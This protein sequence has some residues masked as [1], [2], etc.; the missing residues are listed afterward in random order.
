MYA[1]P[2]LPG[3]AVGISGAIQH[4]A[5]MSSSKVGPWSCLMVCQWA[6]S[7]TPD[8]QLAER[9]P[10]CHPSLHALP[11]C[12]PLHPWQV[13]VAI[14]SDADAPIFQVCPAGRQAAAA[15]A[16][17]V[18]LPLKCT[19]MGQSCSIFTSSSPSPCDHSLANPCIHQ[20][21][22]RPYHAC[23]AIPLLPR[24]PT[25]GCAAT[26]SSCCRSWMRSWARP[27]S[28]TDGGTVC[29]HAQHKCASCRVSPGERR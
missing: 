26:C 14:N 27:S 6:H 17:A 15:G 12:L 20:P 3:L 8:L 1:L 4:V 23:H 16:H 11:A 24:L 5:G 29:W 2:L 19:C 13:I 10:D 9:S 21:N 18:P 25:T 22:R 7:C 28:E